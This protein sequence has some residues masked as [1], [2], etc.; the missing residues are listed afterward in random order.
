MDSNLIHLPGLARRLGVPASWLRREADAGRLPCV[1]AG[2]QR[3]FDSELVERVLLERARGS[4]P[5]PQA[6]GAP[7]ES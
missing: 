6:P 2:S 5:D 4:A 7:E 1:R 3:L